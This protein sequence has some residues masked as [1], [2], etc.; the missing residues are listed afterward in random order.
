MPAAEAAESV[1]FNAVA[2]PPH[3]AWLAQVDND[4]AYEW[5]RIQWR[6]AHAVPGAWFDAVKADRIVALWPTIFTLTEDR[7][8][9]VPFHLS[10]WQEIIV[11]F[12]VGFK[13]PVE[14]LDP[15]THKEVSVYV[16]LYKQLRL[17]IPRKNGKSEF[18]AAL[19]LLF[20]A[21]DG[22]QTGR[23][24]VFA[25]DEKQA[26]VI[27]S[28]MSMMVA[29]LPKA[30]Q[31]HIQVFQKTIWIGKTQSRFELLP[32]KI[33][34]AHGRSA[35]VIT[36]D[37]M[38]EWRSLTL[39]NTLRQST[40]ARLEPIELYASS[41]GLKTNK[42]GVELYEESQKILDGRI[43][44]PTTLVVIFAANDN[45]DIGL[46]ET[47]RSCNPSLG[48]SPTIPYLR[49]EHALTANNPR[50]EAEF[51]CYHL[52]QWIEQHTRWINMRKWDACAKGKI[53][54]RELYASLVN[55]DRPCYGGFDVSKRNDIT[56]LTWLFE[57]FEDDPDWLCVPLFWVPEETMAWRV[58]DDGVPYDKWLAAGALQTT[59]GNM[60]DQN[61]IAK[62]VME[63]VRD[64]NVQKIS[65]DPW[66]ATKLVTDLQRDGVDADLFLEVRQG[67]RTLSEPC[68]AFEEDVYAGRFQHGGHPVLRWMAGNVVVKFDE[69]LNI[70]PSKKK[71]SEKID[72]IS[73][74]VNARAATI[75]TEENPSESVYEQIAREKAEQQAKEQAAA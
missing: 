43:E 5:A 45:A 18:L 46:E 51:R 29:G 69:N 39:M 65:F 74:I 61:F 40:G 58:R 33:A 31:N 3:P 36:G 25:H 67:T 9:G 19:S 62:A 63:G 49:R 60:V 30:S 26:E 56:A 37:E 8:A 50:R 71:S 70:M 10:V 64:F 2:H 17:W 35:T 15:V 42:I 23:G 16:R 75:T 52:G 47:W 13:V 24:Y 55:S 7:F 57:P 72:G 14:V 27:F 53:G 66:N 11:R 32:G 20:F 54:W 38:H 59:P 34:G 28:K 44:D 12:L 73:A 48:L 21:I 22:A 68:T 41:A 6:R 1:P 4:P